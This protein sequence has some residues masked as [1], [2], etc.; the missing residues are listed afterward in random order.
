MGFLAGEPRPNRVPPNGLG[1]PSTNCLFVTD[2]ASSLLDWRAPRW[3]EHHRAPLGR[4]AERQAQCLGTERHKPR[5]FDRRKRAEVPNMFVVG[6]GIP[7]FSTPGEAVPGRKG[8]PFRAGISTSLPGRID[9]E[10]GVLDAD[11]FAG[12]RPH[13]RAPSS[14]PSG[15]GPALGR[16]LHFGLDTGW[17]GLFPFSCRRNKP[18]PRRQPYRAQPTGQVRHLGLRDFRKPCL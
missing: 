17:A 4:W 8:S 15:C 10:W 3:R 16:L 12:Y 5:D 9:E 2:G 18:T 13:S 11:D 14:R 6:P 7:P 1:S